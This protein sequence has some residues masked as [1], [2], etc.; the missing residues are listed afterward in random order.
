MC[1]AVKLVVYF[2][3]AWKDHLV[4][5]YVS[6]PSFNI[7]FTC[8]IIRQVKIISLI[9][10]LELDWTESTLNW[11][12]TLLFSVEVIYSWNRIRLTIDELYTTEQNWINIELNNDTIA[13]CRSALELKSNLFH[14]EWILHYWTELKQ[15]WTE[16]LSVELLYSW[17]RIR[18]IIDEL[19]IIE[20]NWININLN[21]VE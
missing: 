6:D 9:T 1:N 16:L 2:C 20:K 8:F 21:W 4:Y 14:N 17:S 5:R 10:H 13:F 7:I 15:H 3:L 11:I 19:F 12:T 18:F